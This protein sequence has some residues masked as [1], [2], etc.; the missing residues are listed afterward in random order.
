MDDVRDARLE[1]I[2]GA[3][4]IPTARYHVFVCADQ[5]TPR[6]ASSERS[7][8]VW[9]HLKRRLGEL[10]LSS[11]PPAWRGEPADAPPPATPPGHGPVLRSK[12]D[13]LRV[14][15]QGPIVVV[16]PDG[17][18]YRLV[19]EAAVDRIVDEHLLGGRVVDDLRFATGPL[20]RR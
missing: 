18:W 3:L 4:G 17:V 9:T 15:E 7:R 8:E 2:A 5:T 1:A 12:V 6:C 19:D 14:C 20:E 11:P 10:D 16:Y 13:C